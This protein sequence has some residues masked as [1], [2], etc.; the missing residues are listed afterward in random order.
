MGA[1]ILLYIAPIL[2]GLASGVVVKLFGGDWELAVLAALGVGAVWAVW[3]AF[4][5]K[6]AVTAAVAVA[7]FFLSR[8]SYK[9]GEAAQKA[10]GKADATEA[11]NKI[12]STR[13]RTVIPDERL[14]DNDGY[15]R[16]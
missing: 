11:A 1:L 12:N 6:A 7:T 9:R 3:K 2:G 16:D 8:A 10:K 4:G 13:D 15:R 14:R 5:A